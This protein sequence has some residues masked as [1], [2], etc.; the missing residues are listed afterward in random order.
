MR[1]TN[2]AVV[3]GPEVLGKGQNFLE[4]A[5]EEAE[6]E[7]SR[8][9]DEATKLRHLVLNAV[10]EAQSALHLVRSCVSEGDDEEVGH[11]VRSYIQN[12]WK[13]SG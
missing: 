10:N 11:F 12:R 3:E 4:T 13:I 6:N 8:L 7:R 5:L 1:C 2:A 9:S